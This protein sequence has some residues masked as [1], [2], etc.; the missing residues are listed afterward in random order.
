MCLFTVCDLLLFTGVFRPSEIKTTGLAGGMLHA[1]K[2][3]LPAA[4]HGP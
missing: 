1:F 4:R 3:I 2:A